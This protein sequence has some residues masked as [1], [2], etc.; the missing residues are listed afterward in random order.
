MLIHPRSWFKRAFICKLI[1]TDRR[2]SCGSQVSH[3]LEKVIDVW[4]PFW[5]PSRTWTSC[6]RSVTG[7]ALASWIPWES[8]NRIRK[9]KPRIRYGRAQENTDEK[10][11]LRTM[12][13]Y[14]QALMST[15]RSSR[16]RSTLYASGN[17]RFRLDEFGREFSHI[18]HGAKGR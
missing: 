18:L 13:N 11:G 7:E 12:H 1:F 16:C 4:V 8:W 17:V 14:F 15:D 6:E 5:D 2:R 3:F 10:I 9:K